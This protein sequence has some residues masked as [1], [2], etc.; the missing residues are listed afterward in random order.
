MCMYIYIYIYIY[1]YTHIYAYSHIYTNKYSVGA[2]SWGRSPAAP[3]ASAA[4][5]PRTWRSD[6]VL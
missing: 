1:I 2:S 6:N 4:E 5:R 3:G